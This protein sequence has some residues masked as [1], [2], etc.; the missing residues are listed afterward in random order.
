MIRP[1]IF[2][3]AALLIASCS[4]QQANQTS[5]QAAVSTDTSGA[6]YVVN[7]AESKLR[8]EANKIVGGH[9]GHTS[10]TEGNL[11]TLDGKILSGRFTVDLNSITSEDVTDAEMNTKLVNHLKS[12]DF[13]NVE[14]YPTAVFELTSSEVLSGDPAGNTHTISGNL[15]IKDSVKNISFPVKVSEENGVLTAD[16]EIVINRLQWGIVYNSVSVSPEAL[17]KKLGDN[18]I[19]DEVVFKVNLKATKQ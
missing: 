3:S 10:I 11:N 7:P 15:S 17:L 14:A 4:N 16:A 2:L 6:N 19:K 13:F 1:F 5:E 8:W 12:A 18:A 9:Y